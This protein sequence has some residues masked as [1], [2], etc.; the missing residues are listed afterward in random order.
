MSTIKVLSEI[1]MN[2]LNGSD[3]HVCYYQFILILNLFQADKFSTWLNQ[4]WKDSDVTK[5]YLPKIN[6]FN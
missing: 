3:V 6:H 5:H 4:L 1:D 2:I